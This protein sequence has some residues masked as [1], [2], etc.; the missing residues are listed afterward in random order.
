MDDLDEF[1]HT[2]NGW[3]Y[4]TTKSH[5]MVYGLQIEP[6]CRRKGNATAIL[7]MVIS[8]IRRSGYVGEITI[9]ALPQDCEV[10]RDVLVAF[11]R[12]LGFTI[13]THDPRA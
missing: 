2:G 10:S 3:C 11:Y 7:A 6:N 12:R 5:P 13:I 1:V 9:E 4:W 8:E